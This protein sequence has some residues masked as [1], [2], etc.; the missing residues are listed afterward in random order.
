MIERFQKRFEKGMQ[1]LKAGLSKPRTQKPLAQ[2]E[3][4]IG[5]LQKANAL[6]P[7]MIPSRLLLIRT[8]KKRLPLHGHH[9]RRRDQ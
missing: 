6:V 9:S 2:V 3:R 7:D 8:S 4:K 1:D 5:R